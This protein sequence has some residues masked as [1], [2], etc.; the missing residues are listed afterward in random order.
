MTTL[1]S[2]DFPPMSLHDLAARSIHCAPVLLALLFC[3]LATFAQAD[4]SAIWRYQVQRGDTLFLIAER[5]LENSADWREI[6]RVNKLKNPNRIEPNTDLLLPTKLLKR[7]RVFAT[8][9][10]VDG[11]VER[12]AQGK[13][14]LEPLGK[15]DLIRQGDQIQTGK[16]GNAVVDFVDGSQLVILRNSIVTFRTLQGRAN[17]RL[18]SVQ[19][20]LKQGRVETRVIPRKD[21]GSVYEIITPTVQIGVRGT[22]FRV[23][24]GD[25]NAPTRTEV[26]E[27]EVAAGNS[28]GSQTVPQG[29]GTLV[30][31]DQAPLPPIP[32]LA[33]PTPPNLHFTPTT[34]TAHWPELAKAVSYRLLIAGNA[35]FSPLAAEHV[36]TKPEIQLAQLPAGRYYLQLR[37]IDANGLEGFSSVRTADF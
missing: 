21:N 31:K 15:G 16:I 35:S 12:R 30:E 29:F 28:Q 2:T 10:S 19:I 34:V 8:I 20:D 18:A 9:V 26:M 5:Y 36:T 6:Q 22:Q 25:S 17:A 32:L 1:A 27:G 3:A 33:A 7:Q 24:A 4:D 37:A 23:N 14:T 13:S 11:A